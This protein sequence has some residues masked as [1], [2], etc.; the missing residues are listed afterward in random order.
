MLAHNLY[1]K[2]LIVAVVSSYISVL[3]AAVS[4]LN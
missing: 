3:N 4:L 1:G 2:Y